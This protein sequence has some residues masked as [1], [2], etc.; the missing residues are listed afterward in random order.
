MTSSIEIRGLKELIERMQKYPRELQESVGVTMD[1]AMLALH[2]NVPPYPERDNSGY[3]RTGTL[4]RTLGSSVS[5]GK[6]GK[7][8]VYEVREMGSTWEGHFG[9]N[10]E[11]APHVIGPPDA[12]PNQAWMHYRWWTTD[13]VK[14]KA[15][16]KIQS[17]FKV[18][19]E[20]LAKWLEGKAGA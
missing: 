11:Y 18:L 2:E 15:E 19:A 3:D 16:P 6:S 13:T 7:P 9:T 20:K 5:G 4:G 8:D 1:A 17:L 12:E 14:E 10:L